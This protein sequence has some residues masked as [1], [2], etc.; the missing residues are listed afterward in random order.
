MGRS[1]DDRQVHEI[2]QC[3]VRMA[4][5]RYAQGAEKATVETRSISRK[6][7]EKGLLHLSGLYKKTINSTFREFIFIFPLYIHI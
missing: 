6:P 3:D 7:G 1:W 2:L 5:N 4:E